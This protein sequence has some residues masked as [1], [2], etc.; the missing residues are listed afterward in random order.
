[1][2]ETKMTMIINKSKMLTPKQGKIIKNVGHVEQKATQMVK[3]IAKS[4]GLQSK[5]MKP[6][7][8]MFR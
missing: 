1:M 2:A 5:K 8:M 4:F 7:K 6:K 3:D